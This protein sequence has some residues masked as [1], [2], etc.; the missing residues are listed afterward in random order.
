MNVINWCGENNV[1]FFQ[2]PTNGV[3]RK[4]N[5][6]NKWSSLRNKRMSENIFET[7]KILNHLKHSIKSTA[8]EK[9][10]LNSSKEKIFV[11]QYFDQTYFL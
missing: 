11:Y 7:P 4:L 10:N 2:Y 9:E 5:D 3:I 8:V 6:R 1:N